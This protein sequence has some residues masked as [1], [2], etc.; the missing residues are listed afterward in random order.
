[1]NPFRFVQPPDL[2]RDLQSIR[3]RHPLRV[4]RPHRDNS[5]EP[6]HPTG[7]RRPPNNPEAAEVATRGTTLF[8]E[9]LP[10]IGDAL[11]IELASNR[12]GYDFAGSTER[13]KPASSW[14]SG[15]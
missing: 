6:G 4:R 9:T 12:Y 10:M 3:F 2:S 7:P 14:S 1:M 5:L 8:G 15:S 11:G 13:Q